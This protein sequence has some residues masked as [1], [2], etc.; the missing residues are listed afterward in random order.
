MFA[1]RQA[2][3]LLQ[4]CTSMGSSALAASVRLFSTQL[5]SLGGVLA[6]L[7]PGGGLVAQPA[8][9]GPP[10]A[11]SWSSGLPAL[12]GQHEL[13]PE[14]ARAVA[15]LQLAP[16]PALLPQLDD[17]GEIGGAGGGRRWL[18]A[19]Q[20]LPWAS[21]LYPMVGWRMGGV[22]CTPFQQP[23]ESLA[24]FR[25]GAAAACS[26]LQS[27]AWAAARSPGSVTPS[28]PTSPALS[29]ASG[30]MASSRGSAPPAAAAWWLA[31]R[32]GAGGG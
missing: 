21:M 2:R 14:T 12:L 9:V 10:A 20:A 17:M 7:Q 4:P 18:A 5:E 26:A 13:L 1:L 11:A 32:P 8:A 27:R 28:A 24:C 31:A 19:A 22:A 23:T 3:S 6:G 29:S 25:L 15:E 16:T 30:G